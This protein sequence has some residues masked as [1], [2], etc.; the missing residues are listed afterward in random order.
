MFR[1]DGTSWGAAGLVRRGEFSDREVEF[2]TSVAPAL[3]ATR[4]AAR[5]R[6]TGERAEP[7]IVV[8][9]PDGGHRAATAVAAA[10][11]AELDEIAPGRFAVLLCAV[12]TGPARRRGRSAPGCATRTAGGA[13]RTVHSGHRG[14]PAISAHAVQDH[15]KSV[16]GKVGVR[17]RGE[18][19]AKLMS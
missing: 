7:A 8:V 19:T 12:V 1:V 5:A 10:W 9:G 16:F 14:R 18:L 13:G 4:V 2:L 3:A 17:S 6:G 15:L 11:H